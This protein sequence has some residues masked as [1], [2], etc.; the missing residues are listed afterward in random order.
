MVQFD[1]VGLV[2]AMTWPNRDIQTSVLARVNK[3]DQQ[4]HQEKFLTVTLS[5]KQNKALEVL[6][7]II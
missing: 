1:R 3:R 4:K 7:V 2:A 5:E 6:L